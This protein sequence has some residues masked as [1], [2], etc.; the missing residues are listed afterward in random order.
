MNSLAGQCIEEY[1]ESSHEG[2][3]LTGSHLGDLTLM[4]HDTSDE[5]NVIVDHV[6]GHLVT[7]C[8]PVVLP[9]GIVTVNR[10]ELLGCA[11]VAV[12]LC[13]LYPDLRVFC[14]SARCRLHDG[15]SLR[16]N[17]VEYLLDG[18]VNLLDKL[19]LLSRQ[20]LLLI[21]RNLLLEFRLDF[22]HT[23]L[24]CSDSLL[25]LVLQRLT[26]CSEV[27][28]RKFVYHLVCLKHLVQGRLDGLHVTVCLCTE[29]LFKNVCK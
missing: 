29:N 16:K 23:C 15:E 25:N 18:L 3:T 11:E 24:I 20:S 27:V 1:R 14:E 2:L 19:V 7:A 13:S 9:Y 26:P 8:D 22:S 10:D 4:Q 5:L 12:E 21:E 6:P 17:L 28:I